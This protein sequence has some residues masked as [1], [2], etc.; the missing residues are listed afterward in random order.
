MT[1]L[2]IEKAIR[3]DV[4]SVPELTEVWFRNAQVVNGL[5]RS[6]PVCSGLSVATSYTS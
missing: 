3:E 4:D 6:I 5:E 2:E 1:G